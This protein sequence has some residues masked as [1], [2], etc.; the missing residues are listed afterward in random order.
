V[1]RPGARELSTRQAVA[2]GLLHG[3]SELLPISSS[4]HTALVPWLLGWDYVKLDPGLRKSFEV[5]LHAGTVLGLSARPPWSAGTAARAPGGS[6]RARLA[7]LLCASAPPALAGYLFGA[8]IERRLGTPSTIAA[9]L[10]AGAA[11]IGA[12]DARG[13][14]TRVAVD[15]GWRDG[16][17]LGAAQTLALMPG[18]SRSGMTLAA[19]RLRGFD[20]ADADRLSWQAGL[21]VIAGAA[22]LKSVRQAR[23]GGRA[24]HRR[25]LAA[26]GGAALLSAYASARAL[27]ARRRMRLLAGAVAYRAALAGIVLARVRAR[28]AGTKRMWP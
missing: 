25:L 23:G 1:S 16:I 8:R 17:A 2:L 24:E 9:G 15:A 11:A 28:A 27:P 10:L 19:A 5:A 14:R 20:R 21:P 22:L 18:L 12:A 13:E 3:P 4:A 7:A 26:G 6:P